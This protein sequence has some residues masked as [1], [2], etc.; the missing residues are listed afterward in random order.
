MMLNSEEISP[1]LGT[2]A[3]RLTAGGTLLLQH[4]LPKLMDF[5]DLSSTFSD[6]L[7]VGHFLSLVMILFA[8]V[9]CATLVMLG[10]WTRLSSIPPILGMAVVVFMQ[11]GDGPF[12]KQELGFL[13]MM[14][15]LA[16]FLLGSGRFSLDRLNFR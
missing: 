5:G 3:L 7:G 1:D 11:N 2:L 8:E 15:F 6:P 13:Y 16:V 12:K 14:A 4:G 9:A 10:L